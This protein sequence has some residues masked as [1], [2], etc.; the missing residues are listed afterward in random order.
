MNIKKYSLIPLFLILCI[1]LGVL[2]S[3][4]ESLIKTATDDPISAI[5]KAAE[6]T[7]EQLQNRTGLKSLRST[8]DTVTDGKFLV[9]LYL[10]NDETDSPL[11]HSQSFVDSKEKAFAELLTLNS[12]EDKVDLS[13][14]INS[15]AFILH[16]PEFLGEKALG[17]RTGSLG[18]DL[19]SWALWDLLGVSYEEILASVISD[20]QTQKMVDTLTEYANNL[21][22]AEE[23]QQNFENK[24]LDF[25]RKKDPTV[26]EENVDTQG[27][28]AAAVTITY[29]LTEQDIVSLVKIYQEELGSAYQTIFNLMDSSDSSV[30][31]P[32]QSIIDSVE[33]ADLDITLRFAIEKKSREFIQIGLDITGTVEENPGEIHVLID[34][35]RNLSKTEKITMR[36]QSIDLETADT[37]GDTDKTF[38]LTLKDKS[39]APEY[40]LSFP[41]GNESDSNGEIGI[42]YKKADNAFRLWAKIPSDDEEGSGSEEMSLDGTLIVKSDEISFKVNSIT[43]NGETTEVSNASVRLSKA[44]KM[45]ETP[46]F[47]NIFKMDKEELT[48]LITK[49]SQ[50]IDSV[51]PSTPDI[52][53]D[54]FDDFDFSDDFDDFD[55]F[56]DLDDFDIDD[57][58]EAFKTFDP[59]YDYDMDGDVDTDDY[60]MWQL[61][62]SQ[63]DL[64]SPDTNIF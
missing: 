64:L 35:G 15:D 22:L 58:Y 55:F 39:D 16:A 1:A 14:Y 50:I 49:I 19:K 33:D 40:I 11:L 21:T 12:G 5:S 23:S 59:A 61:I 24:I 3:C 48:E 36:F 60:E 8:F 37:T 30:T 63:L 44:D 57:L 10:P 27:E 17:F 29:K 9:D 4:Q 2:C 26:A 46:D 56:D 42:Q 34:F 20:D 62:N 54:D 7:S 25:L 18:E 43:A 32:F 45:P 28:Q 52:D 13:L 41:A 47:E 51:I 31:D 6:A 53:P 38:T